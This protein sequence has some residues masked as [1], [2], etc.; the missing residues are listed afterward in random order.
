LNSNFDDFWLSHVFLAANI[1][2]KM[3]FA[4]GQLAFLPQGCFCNAQTSCINSHVVSAFPKPCVA[5]L[6]A[7]QY[8][9]V[10][11]LMRSVF[12]IGRSFQISAMSHLVN[13]LSALLGQDS[14]EAFCTA[15]TLTGGV[16]TLTTEAA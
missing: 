5:I 6:C 8:M 14:I 7:N 9:V 16:L 4:T 11:M 13:P 2:V 15:A 3:D 12:S 10:N 1:V